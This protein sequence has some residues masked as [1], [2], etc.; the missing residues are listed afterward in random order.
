MLGKGKKNFS[1]PQ[2][3]SYVCEFEPYL[4]NYIGS[5]FDR[6][7]QEKIEILSAKLGTRLVDVR[8]RILGGRYDQALVDFRMHESGDQWRAVDVVFEGVSA[9][10]T[11]RAQ[12][13]EVL[14]AGGPERLLQWLGEQNGARSDC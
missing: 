7:D 4:S 6:Y 1:R 3:A 8:T 13:R 9:V 2:Y 12:F 11:L 14:R 5:R 10:K